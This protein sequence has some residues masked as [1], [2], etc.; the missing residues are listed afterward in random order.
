MALGTAVLVVA[1]GAHALIDPAAW[2]SYIASLVQQSRSLN[3]APFV[4]DQL[5]F[6]VP[7]TLGDFVL[8]LG[9]GAV[10]VAVAIRYRADWLAF[11]AAAIAVPTLWVAR[12]AAVVGVPLL[13]VEDRVRRAG[14]GAASRDATRR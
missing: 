4:G 14:S 10:L 1:F 12:L 11:L 6:L 5:L 3:D 13:A 2:R 7:S 8:R 9:I